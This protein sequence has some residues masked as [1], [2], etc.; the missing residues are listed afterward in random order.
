LAGATINP[1]TFVKVSTA[2]DNTA[3][4]VADNLNM[5]VLRSSIGDDIDKLTSGEA[6]DASPPP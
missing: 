5:Q 2:A 6:A 4:E 1:A 3:L